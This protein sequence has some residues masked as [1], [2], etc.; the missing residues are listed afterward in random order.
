MLM[1]PLPFVIAI[2]VA[3]FLLRELVSGE[4][5]QRKQWFVSFL[6]LFVFQEILIGL[7]FGYGLEG[8]RALQPF[9]AALIPPLAYL[10]FRRPRWSLV[11]VL[12][13]VPLLAVIVSLIIWQ[14][15]LDIVLAASNIAY[16]SA[17]IRLG[18][19]G[20][21]ALGWV[22]IRRT[23]EILLLLWLVSGV[24]IVSGVTDVAIVYDFMRTSGARTASI[25]SWASAIGIVVTVVFFVAYRFLVPKSNQPRD[26]DSVRNTEIYRALNAMMEQDRLHLDPDINLNRIARRMVLPTREVSRAVNGMTGGNVSQFINKM[27]I[28]EACQLLGDTNT[29]ITQIVFASGFNTKSNFNREFSRIK[30]QSPREWREAQTN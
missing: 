3:L 14:D 4:D 11:V 26:N 22:K 12:H 1:I 24:L 28:E 7:R 10:G 8:L 13:L 23:R 30:G 6:G 19:G 9:S 21:D 29:P 17:L 16:A 25:A 15:M 20:S 18:L 5:R 2:F 27:R